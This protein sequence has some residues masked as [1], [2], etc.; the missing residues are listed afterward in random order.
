MAH[1]QRITKHGGT[2]YYRV[3]HR[4]TER[5][6]TRFKDAQAYLRRVQ[7][8]DNPSRTTVARIADRWRVEHLPS[9]AYHTIRGYHTK[10]D[11][12]I[13]PYIG[14]HRV[15]D[16]TGKE[17]SDWLAALADRTS[18]ATANSTLRTLRAMIRW[19]RGK[20]LCTTRVMDDVA[21]LSQPQPE[22]ARPLTPKQVA[23]I[24]DAAS[25]MRDRTLIL[26]AAYTGL[27]W[28]ELRA[29]EW[30]DIDLDE[31]IIRVAKAQASDRRGHTK[32]PKNGKPRP[33][34]ILLPA[35][36]ALN[37]WRTHAPDSGLVFPN[38]AGGPLGSTWRRG[39]L[40]KEL[41]SVDEALQLHQLRDTYAS[42]L[43]A[44]G[45]VSIPELCLRMGHGSVQ[46]TLKRYA[47]LYD[48]RLPSFVAS[49]DAMLQ[50]MLK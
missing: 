3:R 42:L 37:E 15:D 20:G 18:S 11:R 30:S 8:G 49:S 35:V 41:R 16:L 48:D 4:G 45:E 7:S 39:V 29:L 19:G 43:I 5:T 32:P 9:L 28:S 12:H 26:V 2:R 6:F 33:V 23:T 34:V 27:R 24:A 10:L 38:S 40:D 17:I 47:A 21:T 50:S 22:T 36:Q 1:L 13:L 14:D 46:T 25:R 44:T 31:R